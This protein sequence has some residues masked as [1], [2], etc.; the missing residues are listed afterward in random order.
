MWCGRGPGVGKLRRV[1]GLRSQ[2]ALHGRIDQKSCFKAAG[3]GLGQACLSF[4][5]PAPA[6][7]AIGAAGLEPIVV[8]LKPIEGKRS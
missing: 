1:R 2:G 5:S 8:E 6:K 3:L 4:G 7:E